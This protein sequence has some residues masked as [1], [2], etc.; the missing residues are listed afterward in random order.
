MVDTE[1]ELTEAEKAVIDVVADE[2]R[3]N[4]HLVC[5]RTDF[6]EETVETALNRLAS[7]KRVKK[8]ACGLFDYIGDK[9]DDT[10]KARGI[11][12]I[13]NKDNQTAPIDPTEFHDDQ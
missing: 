5:E 8:V 1:D 13:P 7:S 4:S 6:D 3:V 11:P 9:R 2:G 12:E 10:E